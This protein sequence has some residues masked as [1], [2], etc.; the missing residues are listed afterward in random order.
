M[1]SA[2]VAKEKAGP[3]LRPQGR[4][5]RP[6]GRQGARSIDPAHTHRRIPPDRSAPRG[7]RAEDLLTGLTGNVCR[8][9]VPYPATIVE[10]SC[11]PLFAVR[12]TGVLKFHPLRGV[13]KKIKRLQQSGHASCTTAGSI[14]RASS[15]DSSCDS[16][17]PVENTR[18]ERNRTCQSADATS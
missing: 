16:A 15:C 10:K 12:Q 9:T 14:F 6:G 5:H 2:T 3:S 17:R 7:A 13:R 4:R 8:K 11:Q 18:S 1:T